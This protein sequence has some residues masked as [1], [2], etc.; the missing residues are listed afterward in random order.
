[1]KRF[2][3]LTIFCIAV[4]AGCFFSASV[5]GKRSVR[6]K[7]ITLV[8]YDR[9]GKKM[10]AAQIRRM[11]NNGKA[12]FDNDVL[13][14]PKSLKVTK[15]SPLYRSKKTFAFHLPKKPSA[16][17][18]NWPVKPGGYSLI[19]LDNNGKGF[20][21]SATVNFTYQ[22]AL[23]TKRKLDKALQKRKDYVRSK[24]FKRAYKAGTKKL[25]TAAKSSSQSVKGKYG[26]LALDQF[27]AA[28]DTMLADYGP[29]YAGKKRFKNPPWIG[30]TVDRREHYKES[31]DLA[32]SLGGHYAWIRVVF[33]KGRKPS[34]YEKLI[35]YAKS[36]HLKILGQPVDSSDSAG[37]TYK[38]YLKRFKIFTDRF[39]QIDAWEIGN[40]VNGSW[41]GSG[42]PRKLAETAA[43]VR[44][45][46]GKLT[47]L[48]F[49]WQLN[50][51]G[52]EYAL[53]NWMD[54]HVPASVRKHIDCVFLSQYQEQAPVGTA[55]DQVMTRLG[56]EFPRAKIGLGELGYWI[57]GQRYWWAYSKKHPNS[58]ARR[59][60]CHQFYRA[61]L[62]YPNSV[63]GGFWWN[64]CTQ[65]PTD[66]KMQDT[67]RMLTGQIDGC[68]RD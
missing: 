36:K 3:K 17:A 37:Y 32:A 53:F 7:R 42:M 65:F 10:S 39:P 54:A 5:P 45:K 4:L 15:K 59:A 34:D 38:E 2:C 44:K 20:S 31:C 41:T 29:S 57:P 27:A 47:V 33:D 19:I 66:R 25:K 40:E 58:D 49:F 63:G 43:Y 56:K 60:V 23:D 68:Q 46:T 13:V 51:S 8:F 12:G 11:S 62:G 24:A 50:T 22:A 61:A 26:Q 48:T 9:N 67:I 35:K 28:F 18:L 1:M 6:H 64:F 14:S 52:K 30:F 55:F 21:K 16:L